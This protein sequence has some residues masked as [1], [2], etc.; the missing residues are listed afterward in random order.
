MILI[1][2]RGKNCSFGDLQ[3]KIKKECKNGMLIFALFGS[4]HVMLKSESFYAMMG[5][6]K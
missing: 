5:L 2:N 6:R 3:G 4:E 1:L